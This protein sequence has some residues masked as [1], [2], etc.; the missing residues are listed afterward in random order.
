M[1]D[2][3]P[4]GKSRTRDNIQVSFRGFIKRQRLREA[5]LRTWADTHQRNVSLDE[6]AEK[7]LIEK[8][9]RKPEDRRAAK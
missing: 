2:H 6:K 4:W 8:G 7:W 1:N 3:R 5:T 9:F